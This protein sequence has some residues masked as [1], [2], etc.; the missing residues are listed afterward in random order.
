EL[1]ADCADYQYENID[2]IIRQ[3][4]RDYL[5]ATEN[6][7]VATVGGILVSSAGNLLLV[8]T[9]KWSD[10][11]G[12]PG[13]KIDHGET[14]EAA[15]RREIFEETG[16]RVEAVDWLTAQDA[17]NHPEFR[18][19]R[20]FILINYIAQVAGEPEPV[21][22]Y[23]S[24]HIGWYSL[25][26]ALNMDLNQPTRAALERAADHPWLKARAYTGGDN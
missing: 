5:L 21:S 3:L 12:L 4:D 23:E 14:M 10:K 16:L 17:I 2:A 18:Q 22:N 1:A 6:R 9:R 15:F 25:E 11:Y 26:A 8:R 19:P 24:Q 7:V 20:H 13:G